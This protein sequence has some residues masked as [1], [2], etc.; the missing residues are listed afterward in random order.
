MRCWYSEVYRRTGGKSC[1]AWYVKNKERA[2]S[3]GKAYRAT[4]RAEV[5]ARRLGV[6]VDDVRRVL[7]KNE[8]EVCGNKSK[9]VIDHDHKT[10]I[11]RGRLCQGC[12]KAIGFIADDPNRAIKIFGYLQG[13]LNTQE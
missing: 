8:C 10:H 3:N 7:L 5:I 6:N 1:K 12:N 11:V 4:H 9:L 2:L 13:W